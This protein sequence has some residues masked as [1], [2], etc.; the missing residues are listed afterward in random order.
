MYKAELSLASWAVA[1]ASATFLPAAAA[2]AGLQG[3]ASALIVSVASNGILTFINGYYP[4]LAATATDY[5]MYLTGT[6]A[7]DH[8]FTGTRYVITE[9]GHSSFGNTY[10]EG[11]C[12][13]RAGST[14]FA[15]EIAFDMYGWNSSSYQ[16]EGWT[17]S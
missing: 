11:Y 14:S 2:L 17:Y 16:I 15:T 13:Q 1:I 5:S 4:C 10:L 8:T 9:T 3:L 7:A 6:S 12:P